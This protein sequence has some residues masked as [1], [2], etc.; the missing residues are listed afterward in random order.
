MSLLQW[1]FKRYSWDGLENPLYV[2]DIQAANESLLD[3]IQAILGL[4]SADFAIISGMG[5][6]GSTTYQPGVFF[7][8]G[9]FYYIG[10]SFSTGQYLTGS[11]SPTLSKPFPDAVSRTIYTLNIGAATS[12]P[13][14]TSPVFTGNMNQYRFNLAQL[15]VDLST[16]QA[17]L[18]D[19]G[20][21]AFKNTGTTAGTL[22]A[23][24]GTYTKSQVDT[25]LYNSVLAAGSI[26]SVG[27]PGSGGLDVTVPLGITNPDT[28]Y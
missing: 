16:A 24:D 12:S 9:S 8:N 15:K 17:T 2:S 11:T 21:A 1:P 23:G 7:L 5:Y 20:D 4:G 28:N 19:L 22:M 25:M 13:A 14:G 26:P 27:D 18:N 3:A 6:N 10:T